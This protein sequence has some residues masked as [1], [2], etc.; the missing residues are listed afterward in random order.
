[1]TDFSLPCPATGKLSK[2]TVFL[3]LFV[4]PLF[5]KLSLNS[6]LGGKGQRPSPLT[7]ALGMRPS[8]GKVLGLSRG[9]SRTG[10]PALPG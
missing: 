5:P 4:L 10:Q 1:M 2:T 9:P 3:N 8:L 7:A 6:V